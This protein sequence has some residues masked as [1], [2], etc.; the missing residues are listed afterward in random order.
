[1][2][3]CTSSQKDNA[4][5]LYLNGDALEQWSILLGCV[6]VVVGLVVF[7][8]VADL[9]ARRSGLKAAP[10]PGGGMYL[11]MIAS[12]VGTPP[13]MVSAE[14]LYFTH[15]VYI[16]VVTCVVGL[17]LTAVSTYGIFREPVKKQS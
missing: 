12:F 1:M 11:P 9:A 15:D 10:N 4:M 6:G 2:L 13:G 8:L 5:H 16:G 17:M 7:Y 14:V 3:V